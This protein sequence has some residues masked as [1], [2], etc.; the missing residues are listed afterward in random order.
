MEWDVRF[1][2]KAG[3]QYERLKKSGKRP[4]IND[5]IDFLIL[6]LKS[7]GPERADWP[8]YGKLSKS[9]FHCHLKKGK[10]TYVACWAILDDKLKNIEI[11]YVGTHESAPY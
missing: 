8:N 3:N 7:K 11:Y 9:S 10:P 1:S 6:E 5:V 4:P 2:R